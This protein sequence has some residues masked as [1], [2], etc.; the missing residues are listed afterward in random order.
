[1]LH[2]SQ[3]NVEVTS[4]AR[5]S[6]IIKQQLG[7]SAEHRQMV[8]SRNSPG[9]LDVACQYQPAAKW[10]WKQDLRPSSKGSTGETES[11]RA[12]KK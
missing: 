9:W 3:T 11:Q 6:E 1:M 5:E 12:L 2:S 10:A 8:S 7:L 4:D